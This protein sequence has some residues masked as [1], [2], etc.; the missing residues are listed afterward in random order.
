MKI[1]VENLLGSAQRIN[2]QKNVDERSSQN[3][4]REIKT[5]SVAIEKK[6]LSHLDT[7]Q[8]R[9]KET[10][11]S[12]TRNQT[13][14]DGMQ[15]LRDDMSKGGLNQQSILNN[16]RY[17]G[18]AVL[19]EFMG[20]QV[21]GEILDTRQDQL[22]SLIREDINTISRLQIETENILA[23]DIIEGAQARAQVENIQTQMP[24]NPASAMGA[25]NR[26]DADAVMRLVK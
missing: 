23:S 12:L 19:R 14:M 25:F 6:V 8:N 18:N 13:I 15:Q 1:S 16:V 7:I 17:E 20:E 5:D 9:L 10:Q 22:Q 4:N 26:L 21:T 24:K 11:T 3:R 2:S